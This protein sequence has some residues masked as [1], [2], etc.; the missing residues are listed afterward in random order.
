MENPD[1]TNIFQKACLIQLST[2]VWQ[3]CCKLDES[4]VKRI[5]KSSEWLR[6]SKNLINQELLAP[7]RK[8]ASQARTEIRKYSLPFPINAVYLISKEAL[9][10]VD[11]NLCQY[12]ELDSP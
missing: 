3:G 4:I 11:S 7:V 5:G 10:M 6:G 9:T 1:Y 2:S 12:K 8:C